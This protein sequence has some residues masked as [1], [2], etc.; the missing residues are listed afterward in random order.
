MIRPKGK[1]K[2]IAYALLGKP[3]NII[4]FKKVKSSKKDKKLL[5]ETTSLMR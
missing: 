4:E 2:K 3:S 1:A 5:Y